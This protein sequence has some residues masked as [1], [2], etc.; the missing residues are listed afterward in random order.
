MNFL[1]LLLGLA[2]ERLLTNV[3][4][5]REFRWLDPIFDRFFESY[6]DAERTVTVAASLLL[7]LALVAPVVSV[8][9][10]LDDSM[11]HIPVFILS[12]FVL[13]FCLGPRDLGE[14]VSD[15]REAIADNDL[16]E[17]RA[18]SSELLEYDQELAGDPPD[19]ERAIYAQA[20][21]RIFGVVFW[22]AVLG[23]AGAWLFRVL[24]LFR[25]RAV[26]HARAKELGNGDA[27]PLEVVSVAVMLHKLLAWVPSR[28]LMF[29]YALAG[30][31]EGAMDA[32][33]QVSEKGTGF[34]AE[35]EFE[36][37]GAV[38]CGA[39]PR[40]ENETVSD[41]AGTA[42]ALVV[43]T[44]WMVWAPVLALLTLYGAL[45]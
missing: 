8:Y 30:S 14:E 27:E 25:R 41:R 29:G 35:D 44:L 9:L 4:H 24:D 32:W 1:A 37:I 10:I 43:R 2:V 17:I 28:L 15:Y 16:T 22:F 42:F 33:K 40:G 11:A 20:N 31:Y 45:T 34:L 23:P 7:M 12:V 38:G 3:L 26:L 18:L 39:A 19:I 5:L 21:N 6:D 13:L 36:V